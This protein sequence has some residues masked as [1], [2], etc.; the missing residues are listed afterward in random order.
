MKVLILSD[1]IY[2]FVLGGMQKHSYN[3]IR[4]LAKNGVEILLYHCVR[5]GKDLP[6][7]LLEL[8]HNELA[9]IEHKCFYFPKLDNFPGHYLRES[10][11]LSEKYFNSFIKEKGIDIIYAQGFTAWA[12]LKKKKRFELNIPV[13]VNFHGLEMFQVAASIKT[14]FE[15]FLLRPAVLYN[16]NKAD[17]AISLGG[18]ITSILQSKISKEK[19]IINSIGIE[20]N[21]VDDGIINN[22]VRKLVFIGRDERR[23]GILEL[24]KVISGLTNVSFEL[25]IIGPFKRESQIDNPRIIYHGEIKEQEKV[26]TILSKS[27]VLILPSWSEGMPTVILEAMAKACAIVANDVGA[28]GELVDDSVGWLCKVGDLNSLERGIKAAITCDLSKL[29]E[30]K[31]NAVQRVIEKYTWEKVSIELKDK[32]EDVI[33][34]YKNENELQ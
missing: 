25:H 3:M 10:Y 27:D 14:K 2:P 1:G 29:N 20:A 7:S 4:Y 18:G 13:I 30:L 33:K 8:D 9:H 12:L 24:N 19:V 22:V 23:K 17:Y 5:E 26:A 15:Q 11:H 31:H 34:N 16:L 32:L 21:W 28:V 6:V